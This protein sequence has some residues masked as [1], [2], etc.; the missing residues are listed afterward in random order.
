MGRKISDP[1][2]K[3][4]FLQALGV[5]IYCSLIGL[6]MQ[7]INKLFPKDPKYFG[8]AAFLLLFSFSALI[9]AL[10]VFYEPYRLF[11]DNK[12]KEAVDLVLYTTGWLFMFLIIVFL[13]AFAF[14]QP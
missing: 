9:C 3:R 6:F 10:I 7:N 14:P 1:L 11:F 2:V 5:T 8:P 13:I 12:K 4:G